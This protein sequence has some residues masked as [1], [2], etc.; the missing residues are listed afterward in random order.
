MKSLQERY[1]ELG[2]TP[3]GY[4]AQMG[5]SVLADMSPFEELPDGSK[6]GSL[7]AIASGEGL[8]IVLESG[9][10]MP[11]LAEGLVGAKAGDVREIRVTFPDRM[12]KAGAELEGKKAIF[13]VHCHA[14]KVR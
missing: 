12:G 8:D 10:Y 4:E 1:M 9:R 6:G 13:E 11:G 5:D 14:V 3:E 7:P 2:D